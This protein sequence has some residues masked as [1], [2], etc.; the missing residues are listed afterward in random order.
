MI[1]Y[2]LNNKYLAFSCKCLSYSIIAV[3][4]NVSNII[5]KYGWMKWNNHD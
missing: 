2:M 1:N 5:G 3:A 4:V